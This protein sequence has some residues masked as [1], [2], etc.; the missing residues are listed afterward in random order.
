MHYFKLFGLYF[1]L[2]ALNELQYRANFFLELLNSLI[3]LGANQGANQAAPAKS[4]ERV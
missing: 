4:L 2:S 3:A 1:R